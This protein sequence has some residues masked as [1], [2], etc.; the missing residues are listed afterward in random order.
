[1]QNHRNDGGFENQTFFIQMAGAVQT[2]HLDGPFD[3]F[4]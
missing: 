4:S 1:M 3:S 2:F